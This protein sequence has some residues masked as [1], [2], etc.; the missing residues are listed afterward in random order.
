MTARPLTIP[1]VLLIEPVVHRDLRGSFHESWTAREFERMSGSKLEFVQ[2]NH[3][4]STRSVLRGLHYQVPPHAE[5]KIVRVARGAIY[6]VVV[7]IRRSSA[8]FGKWLGVDLSDRNH[9]QLWVPPGFA[10]GYLTQS[11]VADVLYKST[12]YYSP[13]AARQI[14]WSDT[15]IA[16]DWPIDGNPLLSDRDRSAPMLADAELFD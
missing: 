5:G 8:T 4:R 16:I 1:D 12:A 11:D 7:D 2:D 6:D 9:H 10:H 14:L 3:S 15:A 13:E